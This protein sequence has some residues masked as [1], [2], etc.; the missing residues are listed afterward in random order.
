MSAL[1]AVGP[2]LPRP[3]SADQAAEYIRWL[4]FEG[5]IPAG[6][7]VPQDDVARDLG[8]SRVPV[9][10]SLIMLERQGWV[11]IER[12]RGAFVTALTVEAVHDHYELYGLVYGFAAQRA[13]DRSG[14]AF[15]DRLAETL[16]DVRRDDHATVGR[17]I[18]AFHRTVVDAARSPRVEVTLRAISSLV[19][20]DFFAVVPGAIPVEARGLAAIHRAL[21]AGNGER[22]AVEYQRMMRRI[23][24]E[25]IA[26][27][28]DRG[29]FTGEV[30]GVD[31]EE[32][33]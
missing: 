16:R 31:D 21:R 26:V 15:L 33:A 10:E 5:R 32:P 14:D 12:H 28:A 3:S 20:G 23:A 17:A 24:D 18:L 9:R 30:A 11:R 25:V 2:F 29:L 7:R 22:A 1:A 13:L 19:P 6:A 4:I 27:F 8:I